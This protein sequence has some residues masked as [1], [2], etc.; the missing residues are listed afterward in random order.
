MMS[1]WCA[2]EAGTAVGVSR[3]MGVMNGRR[4]DHKAAMRSG[5]T[6]KAQGQQMR[7]TVRI[8]LSADCVVR[9]LLLRC[10]GPIIDWMRCSGTMEI[11]PTV[12][13]DA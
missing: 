10:P 4:V 6:L 2:V 11:T 9:P 1:S 3:A 5:E 8:S 12:I 7:G 13:A